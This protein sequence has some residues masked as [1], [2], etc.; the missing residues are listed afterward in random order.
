MI[1][2]EHVGIYTIENI[3][4]SSVKKEKTTNILCSVKEKHS[5]KYS[6][7]CRMLYAECSVF[8]K[9]GMY[10]LANKVCAVESLSSSRVA[11]DKVR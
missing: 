8:G 10:H 2:I 1:I 6:F 11:L 3:I 9:Q 5:A 4:K 7:L